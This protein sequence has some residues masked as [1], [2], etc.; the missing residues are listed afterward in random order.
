MESRV[1]MTQQRCILTS[2]EAFAESSKKF[3]AQTLLNQRLGNCFTNTIGTTQQ[4]FYRHEM[5]LRKKWL[6][7]SITCMR[8]IAAPFLL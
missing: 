3:L 6:W 1:R 5:N 7:G 2:F 4:L 8:K